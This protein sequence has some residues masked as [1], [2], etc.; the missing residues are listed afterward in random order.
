MLWPTIVDRRARRR[1]RARLRA[2][3]RYDVARRDA[4]RAC[5]SRCAARPRG[6]R[7]ALRLTQGFQELALAPD[8]RKV[9]FVAR[10]EVFA[11]SAKD[12]G[13]AERVTDAGRAGGAARLVARQPPPRLRVGP[14]WRVAPVDVRLRHRRRRRSSREATGERR[15]SRSSRPTASRSRSC[16][17]ASELRVL[18]VASQQERVLA[19]RRIDRRRSSPSASIAWSPDGRWLAYWHAGA[20]GFTNVFVVPAAGG[21]RRQ[22][23]FLANANGNA[24]QWAPT[25]RSSCFDSGQRTEADLGSCAST[26]CRARRG[27]ARTSSATCS[28]REHPGQPTG[29]DGAAAAPA[30]TDGRDRP[31]QRLRTRRTG[32]APA[33]LEATRAAAG[34][35]WRRLRGHPPAPVAAARPGSTSARGHQPR[36]QDAAADRRRRG[37]AEPLHVFARRAGARAPVARQLTTHGRRDKLERQW[38]PDSREVWYLEDGRISAMTVENRQARRVAVSAELDVDFAQREGR[39]VRPGLAAV[40]ATTSSTPK[41]N[42]VD[43]QAATRAGRALRRRRRTPDE[44]R[45]IIGLMIGELNASHLGIN[46]PPAAAAGGRRTARA[47]LRS[48][49]NTSATARLADR[50]DRPARAGRARPASGAAN[51]AGIDGAAIGAAHE[52]RCAARWT[53]SAGA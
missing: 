51:L 26:S 1:V 38:S 30:P 11:A 4:K 14:R 15:R 18:D 3:G 6:R 13:D 27:S 31:R 35:P 17:A 19:T 9:A 48:R 25:A 28:R 16:A 5:P 20:R 40:C 42:G 8:G 41:F 45:R 29:P 39:R 44:L 22:V 53:R 52:P 50:R 46:A 32:D 24:T 10:G 47:A 2:S 34:S 23:S 43:W 12:G 37:P 33:E 36:W 7:R 21:E 49:A